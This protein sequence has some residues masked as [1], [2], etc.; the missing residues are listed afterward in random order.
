MLNSESTDLHD[1]EV[2]DDGCIDRSD[3]GAFGFLA[4]RDERAQARAVHAGASCCVGEPVPGACWVTSGVRQAGCAQRRPVILVRGGNRL[5]WAV[6]AG[7]RTGCATSCEI[8]LSKTSPQTM[9]SWSL[10][11]PASSSRA[12]HP[13]ASRV[14]IPVRLVSN[15]LPHRCIRRLCVCSQPCLYRSGF[16]LAQELD[17][18]S[19]S[20]YRGP[21][22]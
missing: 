17:R 1:K 4:A 21:C 9:R 7:T 19:R 8:M 20:A 12:R 16:V 11:R 18:R 5:L 6:G 13:A 2:I 10:M 14:N 15:E 3:A 22:A